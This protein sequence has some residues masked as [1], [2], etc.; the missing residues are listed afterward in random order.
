MRGRGVD[1]SDVVEGRRLTPSGIEL[2]WKA[3][4]LGAKNALPLVFVQHLTPVEE[5]RKQVPGAGAHPNGATV[6]DRA[7][8]VT[9]NAEAAA[10]VYAKVLGMTQPALVKGTVI[11]SNM[12]VFQIGPTGLGVVQP[13]ADGPAADA[14]KRRGPGPFQALYRTTS[15]ATAARWASEHGLPPLPR[16][17]RNTGEHAML[18]TPDVACGAY[19]GFVGPE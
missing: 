3:A 10:A 16:G 4:T 18:A 15:M 5:R 17:V 7:Y 12:A 19:I 2:K 8:I 9:D 13:Y 11:M 6:L 1:V 14:L